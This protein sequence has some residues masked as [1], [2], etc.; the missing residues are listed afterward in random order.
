MLA[1]PRPTLVDADSLAGQAA[2]IVAAHHLPG[3]VLALVEDGAIVREQAFGCADRDTG[4][5]L[6]PHHVLQAASLAKMVTAWTVLQLAD[7]GRLALDAP[8]SRYVSRWRLPTGPFDGA[9]VTVRRVLGHCAGLSLPDY[10]GFAPERPLPSLEA[11]LSGESNGAGDLRMVEPAGVR[12]RYSG[13]GFTLLALAIEEITDSRFAEHAARAVLEP[14]G[15]SATTFDPPPCGAQATGHDSSGRPLPFF[16]YDGA[17]AAGLSSTAGDLARFAAAHMTGPR[18]ELAGRGV[19]STAAIA[20]MTT[21]QAWTERVDGLWAA[22]GL[23]CEI[24][25]LPGGGTLIGHHGCNRGWRALLA[26]DL[27]ARCAIVLLANGDAAMP[28]LE[29][30]LRSW[31]ER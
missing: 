23:G 1:A 19:I 16:R 5:R 17:A 29:E 9:A 25:P 20:A 31:C 14:L 10:P 26:A 30:V 13:G 8:I 7:Q 21:I 12:F 11:S 22:Y 3:L 6:A 4:T 2:A 28:A 18:G 15:L 24:E 27:D